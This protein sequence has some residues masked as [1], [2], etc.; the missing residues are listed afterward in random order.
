M[1][2]ISHA[3]LQFTNSE[4][5][6]KTGKEEEKEVGSGNP[7]LKILIEIRSQKRTNY[8]CLHVHER[9]QKKVSWPD[10]LQKET[11]K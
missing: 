2:R 10:H 3:S 5:I 6:L 7:Y 9:I 11:P 4:K 8:H 1:D